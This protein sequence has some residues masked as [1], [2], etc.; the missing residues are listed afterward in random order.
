MNK[1]FR[2]AHCMGSDRGTW[3]SHHFLQSAWVYN[4]TFKVNYI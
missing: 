1:Q 2:V 4:R 3:T